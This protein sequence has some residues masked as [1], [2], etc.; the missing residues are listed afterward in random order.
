[1]KFRDLITEKFYKPAGFIKDSIKGLETDGW[2]CEKS[3]SYKIKLGGG[4]SSFKMKKGPKHFLVLVRGKDAAMFLLVDMKKVEKTD[5]L[6]S[7]TDPLQNGKV[8]FSAGNNAS[9]A[10]LADIKK[11]KWVK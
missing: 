1:M 10:I 7:L 9:D 2:E 3:T 11:K 8:T 5:A 6:M 4:V